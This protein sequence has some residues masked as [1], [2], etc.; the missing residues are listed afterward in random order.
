MSVRGKIVG[1]C[2]CGD[3]RFEIVAAPTLTEYCHCHSCRKATG[4]PVMAWAGVAHAAFQ[5][6]KGKPAI[7]ASTPHV[8]RGFCG[9]CGTSLSVYSRQFPDEIY[10]SIASFDDADAVAP[11]VHIWREDRLTWLDTSDDWLRY[12]RFKSDGIVEPAGGSGNS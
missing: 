8:E 9:R 7:Y 2:M 5:L 4:A 10:V 11:E 3:I 6:M 1:G 12:T